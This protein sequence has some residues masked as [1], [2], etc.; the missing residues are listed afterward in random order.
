MHLIFHIILV[1]ACGSS[2]KHLIVWT[3]HFLTHLNILPL[4][5]KLLV[6]KTLFKYEDSFQLHQGIL[7]KMCKAGSDIWLYL[8]LRHRHWKHR[9][10]CWLH[11]VWFRLKETYTKWVQGVQV[12]G[13]P[14]VKRVFFRASKFA[15]WHIVEQD[16]P[17]RSCRRMT[18]QSDCAK[19]RL[20]LS[21]VCVLGS[22]LNS[23]LMA[24]DAYVEC[25]RNSMEFDRTMRAVRSSIMY[26]SIPL[27]KW[28]TCVIIASPV[29]SHSS[30]K[31]KER[32][33]KDTS[34]VLKYKGFC[35]RQ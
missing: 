14:A 12:G 9:H 17:Q 15:H 20:D 4:F 2:T 34:I 19:R 26:V 35:S 7:W 27:L 32:F 16:S 29:M 8:T 22:Q 6:F 23:D 1:Q 11:T 24:H 13:A 10:G 25:Q 30:F 18:S 33:L 5:L 3:I 28:H 31:Y 21:G